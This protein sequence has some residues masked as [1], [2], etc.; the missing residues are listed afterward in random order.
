VRGNAQINLGGGADELTLKNA[1][2]QGSLK[3]LDGAGVANLTLVNVNVKKRIDI[4][5][6]NDADQ[7]DLQS[8]RARQLA[9]TTNGGVDDVHL[10]HDKFTTLNIKLGASRDHLSVDHTRTSL[11]GHIDGEAQGSQFTNTANVLHR[12][13][14]RHLG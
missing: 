6:G 5:T 2:I 4:H 3:V 13:W 14:R 10:G 7:I 11:A 9:M 1:S 8:V 12:L